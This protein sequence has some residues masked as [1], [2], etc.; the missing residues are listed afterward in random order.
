MATD[1]KAQPKTVK[2]TKVKGLRIVSRAP[3]F[4]RAGR[5][6]TSEPIEIPIDELTKEQ[7]KALREETRE[8]VVVDVEIEVPT[9][10][11]SET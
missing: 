10:E 11:A 8:L 6:F 5:E 3:S 1:A 9:V 2:T 7:V 4:R